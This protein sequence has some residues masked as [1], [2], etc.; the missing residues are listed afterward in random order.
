MIIH[1]LKKDI[2]RLR[3]LVTFYVLIIAVQFAWLC[4]ADLSFNNSGLPSMS[5]LLQNLLLFAIIK[6]LIHADPLV[7]THS[8]WLTRPIS[9]A[10]LL[11]SKALFALLFLIVPRVGVELIGLAF[12]GSTAHDMALAVPLICMG[13]LSMII[14]ITV[15]AVVT[16]NFSQ[17]ILGTLASWV[18]AFLVA[19]FFDLRMV[20]NNIENEMSQLIIV[21]LLIILAGGG[22]IIHQ[23]LT[24]KTAR[25]IAIAVIFAVITL[26]IL[27]TVSI[28][29]FELTQ[30]VN[31]DVSGLDLAAIQVKLSPTGGISRQGLL[32][33][34]SVDHLGLEFT[35]LGLPQQYRVAAEPPHFDLVLKN[36]QSLPVE[37]EKGSRLSFGYITNRSLE[38]ALGEFTII[39]HHFNQDNSQVSVTLGLNEPTYNKNLNQPLALFADVK[40]QILKYNITAVMPLEKGAGYDRDSTHLR[41]TD[42]NLSSGG[43][44]IILHKHGVN[45]GGKSRNTDE[46]NEV[47]LLRNQKYHQ[48]ILLKNRYMLPYDNGLR[49]VNRTLIFDFQP[50][51][52]NNQIPKVT[53]EWLADAELVRLELMPVTSFKK[54]V[55][56]KDFELKNHF[57]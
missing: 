22:V 51:D 43:L 15:V 55:E 37:N 35:L 38:F 26:V 14:G 4:C 19:L 57:L 7:G 25:S 6:R 12:N 48:A 23:Y 18:L 52:N 41:I 28:D 8:F 3:L 34:P 44:E 46:I 11:K 24:R 56:V 45:L 50:D 27:E 42:L 21:C 10:T 31:S 40:F 33:S 30:V 32:F 13:Q 9:P 5:I 36:G 20:S 1:L 47:Y 29:F 39:N 53:P 49:L 54:H 17:M 16:R 2:L